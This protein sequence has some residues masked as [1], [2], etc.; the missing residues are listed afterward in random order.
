MKW[1]TRERPKIDRIACPWLVAR[2]IDEDPEFL[3]VPADDVLKVATDTGA[4][5]YD[6][7][8]VE[9][10][11]HGDRCSFD[12]FIEKYKLDDPALNKLALIVRAA[13]CSQPQLAKEAAGLLAIS[14]G[15]S[16]N[17]ADDHE[18]LKAG[19]VVYD[20][21]YAWC[22]DTPLKKVERLPG[23]K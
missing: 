5:P 12:A 13:D 16:L 21:L 3:Y 23:M 18:M 4:I 19:M 17:F 20:A 1:V 10:G 6:V 9:L 2:F 22:A 7:P 8:N 15:L 14:K 11:H